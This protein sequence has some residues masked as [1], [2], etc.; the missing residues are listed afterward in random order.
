MRE[1]LIH[2]DILVIGGGTAGCMAAIA[3]KE[4]KPKSRVVILEKAQIERSGCLAG[5]MNSIN[6]YIHSGETPESFLRYLRYDAMGLIREDLVLSAAGR[7]NESVAR[8]EAWGLPIIKD[9]QGRYQR[10]GRW[11]LPIHGERLKPILAKAVQ[12]AGIEVLNRVTTTG[13]LLSQGRVVGAVG[14]GVRDGVLYKV[15]AGA[16]ICATGGASGIY[17]PNNGGEAQHVMWYPPFNA[18]AGYAM[19]LRAGAE[20]TGLEMRFIA[21]RSKDVIAPTGTLALGFGAPQ[22]NAKGEKFM[23]ARYNH[24]GG[25]GA[26][27]CL[28]V[29]GPLQELKEGRGPCYM[30]TRHLSAERVNDLKASYLDMV[31][32]LVLYWTA[33]GI[34]PTQE[35]VELA[36]TEPYIMGGH[37]QA[38]YWV[39][40]KRRTT[41]PGLYACGDVAG[42]YSYKFVS[43]SWAEGLIAGETAAEEFVD[44]VEEELAQSMAEV[45]RATAPILRKAWTCDQVTPGQLRD[46]VQRIMDEYA[47]GL[48][49][50]FEIN[51]E[52][53][54]RARQE[55][56]RSQGQLQYLAAKDPHELMTANESADRL[57]VARAV[58][59]HLSK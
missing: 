49:S 31:P 23:S 28:R 19:G 55:L 29:Y 16:V 27:T 48:S 3:A 36:A 9:E 40:V 59:E 22:V 47:G 17:R 34:D 14:I 20:L 35:P 25:E 38:G 2:A 42:G 56:K 1:N 43:G 37:C 4:R 32:G 41:L 6:A 39:D 50:F 12:E 44:G 26:P 46:R 30:D 54:E 18:G 11:N 53:L 15:L 21:L 45:E 10:R 51:E 5:G 7:I 57:L 33:N 13:Y 58:V 52:R 8:M 24:I